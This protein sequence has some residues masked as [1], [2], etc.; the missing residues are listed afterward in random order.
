MSQ[1]TCGWG[2]R[3]NEII[4]SPD[5]PRFISTDAD[6]TPLVITRPPAGTHDEPAQ[7]MTDCNTSVLPTGPLACAA[8]VFRQFPNAP[9]VAASSLG[10]I[11]RLI[12]GCTVDLKPGHHGA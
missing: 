3:R 11:G 6:P 5:L 12:G 4:G 2:I 9:A 8:A 1:G 10:M 7:R